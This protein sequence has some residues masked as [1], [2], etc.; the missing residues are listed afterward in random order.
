M[1]SLW[2]TQFLQSFLVGVRPRDPVTM[3]ASIGVV[4]LVAAA[5]TVIPARR[6]TGVNPA[7]ALHG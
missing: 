5:A 3:I 1:A 2:V 4:A 7:T 6:A